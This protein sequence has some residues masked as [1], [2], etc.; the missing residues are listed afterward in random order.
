MRM[1]ANHGDKDT[2][3][4]PYNATHILLQDQLSSHLGRCPNRVAI[5]ADVIQAQN[6]ETGEIY[7]LMGQVGLPE[8]SWICPPKSENWD[9]E[10]EN[11]EAEIV[12]KRRG[13]KTQHDRNNV[14]NKKTNSNIGDDRPYIRMAG[15]GFNFNFDEGESTP[16]RGVGRGSVLKSVTRPGN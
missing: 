9:L 3:S 8:V 13:K 6:E 1:R 12:S 10:A 7:K 16:K 11:H 2:V 5:D 15:R 4:C 14:L